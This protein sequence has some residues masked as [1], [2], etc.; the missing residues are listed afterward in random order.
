[1]GWTPSPPRDGAITP[2]ALRRFLAE[3]PPRP[4]LTLAS[5]ASTPDQ[6]QWFRYGVAEHE[7]TALDRRLFFEDLEIIRN[8]LRFQLLEPLWVLHVLRPRGEK[9]WK[10]V[11]DAEASVHSWNIQCVLR[12]LVLYCVPYGDIAT[13]KGEDVETDNVAEFWVE[14]TVW[15]NRAPVHLEVRPDG[16]M[17]WDAICFPGIIW[18][19]VL[20]ACF[21][22]PHLGVVS[23]A[24]NLDDDRAP[25]QRWSRL[26][27]CAWCGRFFQD[28][29]GRDGRPREFCTS[30]CRAKYHEA[31]PGDHRKRTRILETPQK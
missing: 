18:A 22:W 7:P 1:V 14:R 2:Q 23:W 27:C 10:P 9:E 12:Y 29:P 11:S 16:F 5:R 24:P 21:T 28:P 19:E 30:H 13:R 17:H 3:W 26:R 25:D 31:G 20:N 15:T 6:V 8:L 4:A